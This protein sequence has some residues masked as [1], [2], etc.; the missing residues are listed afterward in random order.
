MDKLFPNEKIIITKHF[1]VHQDWGVPI[2]GF[3]IITSLRKVISIEEFSDD[4]IDEFIQLLRKIRKGMKDTLG[5]DR[6][7]FFQDE[8][9][10]HKIFHIWIFPRHLWMNRFGEKIES[11]R[12][13]IEYSKENMCNE[14][15]FSE[16]RE[17]VS[18]MKEYM[19]DYN[20]C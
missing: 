17:C 9:T 13:I 10:T 12:P 19:K 5:I 18:K 20:N 2:A 11:I 1:D 7:C 14:K 4:E 3:F 8:N 6:V 16:V 15:V